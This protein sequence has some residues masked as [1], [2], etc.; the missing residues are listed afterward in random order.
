MR[1]YDHIYLTGDKHGDFQNSKIYGILLR[2]LAYRK[3]DRE[4]TNPVP[5]CN[6]GGINQKSVEKKEEQEIYII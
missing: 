5:G 3:A 2:A 6:Y 1:E 4:S